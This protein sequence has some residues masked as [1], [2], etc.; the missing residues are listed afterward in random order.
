MS[1]FIV[2]GAHEQ[3]KGIVDGISICHPLNPNVSTI[4]SSG[5]ILQR[6]DC[7][8]DHSLIY[9]YNIFTDE[10]IVNANDANEDDV[11]I[12]SE[13][14]D[15]QIAH[16]RTTCKNGSSVV[17]IFLIANLLIESDSNRIKFICD[18]IKKVPDKNLQLFVI[19]LAYDIKRPDDVHLKPS[20]ITIRALFE[21][22]NDDVQYLM[23]L[24][25]KDLDHS[26]VCFR[27][28]QLAEM[29]A[30]YFMLLSNDDDAY[31]ANN[32]IN[33]RLFSIGYSA[34]KYEYNDFVKYINIATKRDLLLK[35][36]NG[37]YDQIDQFDS[38]YDKESNPFA[39][40]E[41]KN[42]V[43][44]W[45][46][47]PEY[48]ENVNSQTIENIHKKRNDIIISLKEY[49]DAEIYTDR[50]EI[51]SL[52]KGGDLTKL[53]KN[54]IEIFKINVDKYSVLI[55]YLKKDEFFNAAI[56]K[57]AEKII[58][59][60]SME[61][62]YQKN[63]S[64]GILQKIRAWFGLYKPKFKPNNAIAN[65]EITSELLKTQEKQRIRK[66]W[67]DFNDTF[68]TE[69]KAKDFFDFAELK[70]KEL[71]KLKASISCFS[72]NNH[73][74]II[75][76]IDFGKLKIFQ[77]NNSEKILSDIEKLWKTENLN[78]YKKSLDDVCDEVLRNFS[79]D[80]QYI[81]WETFIDG[82]SNKF[83]F[84]KDLTT[85]FITNGLN[86]IQKQSIPFI[87]YTD[88]AEESVQSRITKLLYSNNNKIAEMVND[89]DKILDD[90]KNL[91]N[92]MGYKSRHIENK[93]CMFQIQPI[94]NIDYICDCR[95]SESLI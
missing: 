83:S 92:I 6:K 94:E 28:Q 49:I 20:N 7:N 73:R 14:L 72:L 50:N 81:D 29:L 18:E 25:N 21:N 66:F 4:M 52:S 68:N 69:K 90:V 89:N 86:S 16:L 55:N 5:T 54:E 2:I 60:P 1:A 42:V 32:S 45:V 79:K 35:V 70:E 58:I 63:E 34:L 33:S 47:N 30:D 78:S 85:E 40:K 24:S 61:Q 17:N 26:A 13:I 67:N 51:F 71:E 48:N 3:V 59:V 84:I 57:I 77:E 82:I 44:S 39:L 11:S 93:F 65:P 88:I 53:T 80:Y 75:P 10:N 91:H 38:I 36:F 87:A 76:L 37:K 46:K 56:E 15:N 95:G 31:Y 9:Q 43:K 64:K 23:Y 19:I 74:K 22:I 27:N 41:R 62:E 8:E 12:L